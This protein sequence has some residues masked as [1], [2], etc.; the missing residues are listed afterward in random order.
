MKIY[1]LTHHVADQVA[2][3]EAACQRRK[4]FISP[5]IKAIVLLTVSIGVLLWLDEELHAAAVTGGVGLISTLLLS[6]I[7]LAGPSE[8]DIAIKRSG[9]IGESI[10]PR[11]LSSLPDSYTLLNGVPRPGGRSDIDHVL[12]GPSGIWAIEA[13]NHVGSVQ[14]VGDAW[15]YTRLGRGGI[16]QEGHIG[17][18]AQQA[19]RS[20]ESL[21][22]YLGQHGYTDQVMPLVVFTNPRV[23]LSVEQPTVSVLRACQV[24][25]VLRG[26]PQRLSD[27]QA[28]RIV[29][30]LRKLR[31]S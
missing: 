10:L 2:T 4:R 12:V 20:A 17:N 23:E 13:K 26:Q 16:P 22:R 3:L 9:A 7:A 31:A 1:T 29:S 25:D 28:T 30:A 11:M 19:L 18:P 8:S 15:G 6:A 21:A 27:H 24:L 5:L 14:C